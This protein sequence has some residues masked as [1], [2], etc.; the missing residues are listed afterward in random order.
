[1][2]QRQDITGISRY[3]WKYKRGYS[4]CWPDSRGVQPATFAEISGKMTGRVKKLS[5][6]WQLCHLAM[7]VP[8]PMPIL[9]M[10]F[11]LIFCSSF[12]NRFMYPKNICI[13][14]GPSRGSAYA[15][16]HD[17]RCAW[18]AAGFTHELWYNFYIMKVQGVM[19]WNCTWIDIFVSIPDGPGGLMNNKQKIM[20]IIYERTY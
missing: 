1:M 5:K 11:S 6:L 18:T 15:Q 3:R 8:I 19:K 16:S 7:V 14:S 12:G 9:T 4:W 10:V 13:H 20:E 2:W 17:R